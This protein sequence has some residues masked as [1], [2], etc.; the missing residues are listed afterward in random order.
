[1]IGPRT[2]RRLGSP[3]SLVGR[4]I[5][6]H[7]TAPDVVA[8]IFFSLLVLFALFA[9]NQALQYRRVGPWRDYLYGERAT[10]CSA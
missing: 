10:S 4:W 7:R 6:L 5:G 8:A 9:V 1:V 3:R 2:V